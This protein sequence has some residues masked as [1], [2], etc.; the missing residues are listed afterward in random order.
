MN[1]QLNNYRALVCGASQGIGLA[2][3][4]AFASSGA[5]VTLLARNESKLKEL[6]LELNNVTLNAHSYISVD[7]TN[8]KEL[9][10]KITEYVQKIDSFDIL[11]NNSGGPPQGKL[12]ESSVYELESAFRQ[13]IVSAQV[14]LQALL[15]KMKA[16]SYGRI[17]NIVSIGL[18]QP[19][20]NLGVSNTIRGAMG[21][22]AKTLSR[23]LG[24]YGI[25]VNNI[26]PGYTLTERL[27]TLIRYN[28]EKNR[29]GYTE[30]LQKIQQKIPAK[31]LG[32]PEEIANLVVFLAS[33]LASYINGV[34]IPVDG[35]FLEAI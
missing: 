15:P 10:M 6:V 20:D 19:I 2:I 17:I 14:L 11:V 9:Q 12:Y 27:E 28:A 31:R 8:I 1:I 29:I 30:E 5:T 18:K 16:K 4:K 24:E 3:A 35:G 32:K 21:S 22:W 25:T 34:S 26:L 33:P 13:H 7:M 23:E